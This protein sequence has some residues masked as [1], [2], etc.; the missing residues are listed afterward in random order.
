[1]VKIMARNDFSSG[2]EGGTLQVYLLGSVPLSN[3][4]QLQKRLHFDIAGDRNQAALVLCEHPPMITVGRQGS[5]AHIQFEDEELRIRQWTINWLPRG[6]GC[7]L[8][9][10]G[11]LAVYPIIPLDMLKLSVRTYLAKLGQAL[12]GLL[13]DFSLRRDLSLRAA[14]VGIGNRLVAAF[15]VAVR[16][17]ISTFGAYL[18]IEPDLE[19]FRRIRGGVGGEEP[20]TSLARERRGLVRSAL[21]KERLLEQ[22][23]HHFGFDRIALFTDH[24]A[25]HF[26]TQRGILLERHPPLAFLPGL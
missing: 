3:F 24:P 16:D 22:I 8:H 12:I 21:V 4:I 2:F 10:P 9:L 5:R 25:L 7:L 15:G 13:G 18:N 6:G 14:G 20:M 19:D 26:Q 23:Q 1:M 11:Q 17:W